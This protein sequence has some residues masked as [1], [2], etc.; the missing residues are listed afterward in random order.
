MR[1]LS[2]WK[3]IGHVFSS[4]LVGPSTTQKHQ[5]LTHIEWCSSWI[6]L[7]LHAGRTI[8]GSCNAPMH[9]GSRVLC[10]GRCAVRAVGSSGI[11]RTG[12]LGF[13]RP[14]SLRYVIIMINY[15]NY[16]A[17]ILHSYHS[18]SLLTLQRGSK[19]AVTGILSQTLC[20]ENE[21]SHLCPELTHGY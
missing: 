10:R 7:D 21:F 17:I 2:P 6:M 3:M 11:S 1:Y 20:L 19:G 13:R 15:D 9:S 18:C 4:N 16:V 14:N 5:K 8:R 12:N